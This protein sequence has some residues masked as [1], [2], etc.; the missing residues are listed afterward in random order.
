MNIVAFRT[1]KTA[2]EDKAGRFPEAPCLAFEDAEGRVGS[3]VLTASCSEP[4][5][6][7][8]SCA[9]GGMP[10]GTTEAPRRYTVRF[11]S[12]PGSVLAST[13]FEKASS[14]CLVLV[15]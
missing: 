4:A 1:L 8:A 9:V 6:S 11:E 2:L 14:E 13:D 12:A 7:G 5:D 15:T 3:L 10:L